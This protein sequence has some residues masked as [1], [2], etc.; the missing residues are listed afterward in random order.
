VATWLPRLSIHS[1]KWDSSHASGGSSV[2]AFF[3]RNE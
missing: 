1:R 2:A 3:S